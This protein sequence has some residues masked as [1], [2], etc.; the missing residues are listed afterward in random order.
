MRDILLFFCVDA[1]PV[2]RKQVH[3]HWREQPLQLSERERASNGGG[4]GRKESSCGAT[5][6]GHT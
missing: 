5:F 3:L 1:L 4:D 6:P 2:A